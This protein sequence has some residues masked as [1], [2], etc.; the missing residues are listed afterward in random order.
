MSANKATSDLRPPCR[1]VFSL[2]GSFRDVRILFL[3][4]DGNEGKSWKQTQ[5]IG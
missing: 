4:L 1:V 2:F 5:T 3:S